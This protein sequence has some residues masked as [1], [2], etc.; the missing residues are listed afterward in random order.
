MVFFFLGICTHVG[1]VDQID[2]DLDDLNPNLPL[3]HVVLDLYSTGPTQAI[4]AR[5]RRLYG[6]HPVK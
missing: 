5:S 3:G 2:H 1:Q 4:C 6:S